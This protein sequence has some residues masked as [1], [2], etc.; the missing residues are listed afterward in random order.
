M[1][2]HSNPLR[3]SLRW[4]V[5]FHYGLSGPFQ[6]E[7]VEILAVEP[8]EPGAPGGRTRAPIAGQTA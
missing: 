2:V 3:H 7:D 5:S 6:C 8:H 4:L 1:Q